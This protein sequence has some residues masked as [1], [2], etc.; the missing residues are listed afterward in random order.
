VSVTLDQRH[1][2]ERPGVCAVVVHR[3]DPGG[4]VRGGSAVER[5][6]EI[7]AQTESNLLA[8]RHR[9]SG[10]HGRIGGEGDEVLK[11]FQVSRRDGDVGWRR[12]VLRCRRW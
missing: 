11:Q 1:C 6:R 7:T 5:G 2:A 4:G 10:F 12:A 3:D 9:G 8:E